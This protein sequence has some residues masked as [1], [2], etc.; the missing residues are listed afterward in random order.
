MPGSVPSTKLKTA[1]C[2]ITESSLNQL[3]YC[4]PALGAANYQYQLTDSASGGVLIYT[5]AASSND[6]KMNW[7]SGVQYGRTYSVTVRANVGGAW[8][9]FGATCKVRTP[10]AIPL[11]KL[12]VGDCGRT[13][14]AVSTIIYCNSV[15][16][17]SNYQYR[18]LDDAGFSAYYTKGVGATDFKLSWV[19]G[20]VVN[21]TYKII[22]KANVGG[23]WG[24]FGDTCL[25]TT[26]PVMRL[27]NEA[28]PLEQSF[29]LFP[30]PVAGN[31]LN[32]TSNSVSGDAVIE[33]CNIMGVKVF[34]LRKNYLAGDVITLPIDESYN[35]GVYFLSIT[36]K[37]EK[38]YKK[39][40]IAK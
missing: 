17:A 3:L 23:V 7:V 18:V 31:E 36:V 4:D 20:V 16:G 32:L 9:L 12:K 2:N 8:G 6:F 27:E 19:P 29:N 1:Y 22:V 15:L 25:V 30:N 38:F 35:N 11:T 21:H 13:L 26:G 33:I 34:D 40:I 28:E 24:N 37:G 14:P 10:G 39:F 5:R